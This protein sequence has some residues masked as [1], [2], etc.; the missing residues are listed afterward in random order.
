MSRGH[1]VVSTNEAAFI[2]QSIAAGCR[3]DG[4]GLQDLRD[5]QLTCGR[6][7]GHVEVNWGGTKVLIQVHADV[8]APYPDHP[9]EG[10]FR[11]NAELSPMASPAFEAGRPS[12]LGVELQRILERT[13]KDS[14]SVDTEA[15]CIVA[16][17]K[18]WDINVMVHVLDHAGNIFDAAILGTTAAL[19]H[20]RRPAVSVV[21]NEATIYSEMDRE[22]VTLGIHHI[23]IAVSFGLFASKTGAACD[24][25]QILVMDP[26]LAEEHV[27]DSSLLLAM[28][29]HREICMIH[30]SGGASCEPEHIFVCMRYAATKVK[31]LTELVKRTVKND[32]E[33]RRNKSEDAAAGPLRKLVTQ[34]SAK[35]STIA[36]VEKSLP[37]S[38][39]HIN[40]EA[41]SEEESADDDGDDDDDD[42]DEEEEEEAT[43]TLAS[44]FK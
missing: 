23:P 3:V 43:T 19:L 26:G 42:D 5:V 30:K 41:M 35:V 1:T 28:N 40:E 22:P 4:R 20:F 7:W 31:D 17:E 2:R 39:E 37:E 11:I 38:T 14:R 27:M 15:L 18:V 24:G 12:E 16:S 25:E 29:A 6:S 34:L 13:F 44:N 33:K 21:G 9:T 10:F 32:T 36:V 8:V